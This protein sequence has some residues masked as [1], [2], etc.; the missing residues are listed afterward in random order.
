MELPHTRSYDGVGPTVNMAHLVD[1]SVDT[2]IVT[3]PNGQLLPSGDGFSPSL[4]VDITME[5][6]APCTSAGTS[7]KLFVHA[8]P[9]LTKQQVTPFKLCTFVEKTVVGDLHSWQFTCTCSYGNCEVVE[10]RAFGLPSRQCA[11]VCEITYSPDV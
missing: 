11:S 8:G 3:P 1:G 6:F 5:V 4:T 9:Y 2:C 10:V 7:F